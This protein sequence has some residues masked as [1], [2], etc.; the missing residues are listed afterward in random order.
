[1]RAFHGGTLAHSSVC[2]WSPAGC[3]CFG[4]PFEVERL[5]RNG[6][7]DSVVYSLEDW[8]T[9]GARFSERANIAILPLSH[10]GEIN[11]RQQKLSRLLVV[12]LFGVVLLICGTLVSAA[13]VEWS[14]PVIKGYG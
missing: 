7:A 6:P 10:E 4:K 11:M 13:E 8:C 12:R 3:H 9:R 1:M 2:C 5:C 14:N